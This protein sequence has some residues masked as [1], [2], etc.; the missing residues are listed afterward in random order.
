ML[1]QLGQ[2]GLLAK[3]INIENASLTFCLFYKP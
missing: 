3:A 2:F 1:L